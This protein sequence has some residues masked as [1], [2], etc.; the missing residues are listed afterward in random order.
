MFRKSNRK[1]QEYCLVY[2]CLVIFQFLF[3][4]DMHIFLYLF[5]SISEMKQKH[6][7]QSQFFIFTTTTLDNNNTTCPFWFLNYNLA[8]TTNENH[9]NNKIFLFHNYNL[10]DNNTTYTFWFFN[11]NL[12]LTTNENHYN[13]KT[14]QERREKRDI[15][16][17]IQ[18]TLIYVVVQIPVLKMPFSWNSSS[19]SIFS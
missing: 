7:W 14:I 12:A 3:Q 17:S 4:S 2:N 6:I 10:D 16:V 8:L 11:Y 19:N 15:Q 18:I 1:I 13:N 9:Y 5:W